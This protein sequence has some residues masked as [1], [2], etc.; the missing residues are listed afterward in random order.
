MINIININ[1]IMSE[2]DEKL[3][4]SI[5]GKKYRPSDN[6]WSLNLTKS[7][8]EFNRVIRGYLG[9]TYRTNAVICTIKSEP[10]KMKV[11]SGTRRVGTRT[12][13]IV[14]YNKSSYIVLFDKSNIVE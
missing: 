9:G 3:M 12:M 8:N 10:F 2:K 13:I 6:S 11:E 4:E 5:I 1:K 7:C 14:E